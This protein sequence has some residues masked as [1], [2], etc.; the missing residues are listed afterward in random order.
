MQRIR[1]HVN[2]NA[3]E[4]WRIRAAALAFTFPSWTRSSLQLFLSFSLPLASSKDVRE[5]RHKHINKMFNWRLHFS[6]R[7]RSR[8]RSAGRRA[9]SVFFSPLRLLLSLSLLCARLFRF[10][11]REGRTERAPSVRRA[12]AGKGCKTEKGHERYIASRKSCVWN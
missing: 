1:T 7:K 9:R 8:Y 3:K 6:A 11:L 2:R 12:R 10:F 5:T 4:G